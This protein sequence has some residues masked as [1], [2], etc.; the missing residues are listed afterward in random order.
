M[1][2]ILE[3]ELVVVSSTDKEVSIRIRESLVPSASQ[4]VNCLNYYDETVSFCGRIFY[5]SSVSSSGS[6]SF[7]NAVADSDYRIYYLVSS[8]YPLHPITTESSEVQVTYLST[9]NLHG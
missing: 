9:Y 6:L 1:Y 7:T 2:F 8:E 4:V 5:S 3:T